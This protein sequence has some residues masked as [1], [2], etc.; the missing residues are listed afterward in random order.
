[1][2]ESVASKRATAREKDLSGLK[3]LEQFKREYTQRKQS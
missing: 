1:M 3:R 2:P